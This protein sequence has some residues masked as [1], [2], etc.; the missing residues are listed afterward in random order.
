MHVGGQG[1]FKP[2]LMSAIERTGAVL[3]TWARKNLLLR[4][5]GGVSGETPQ[6]IRWRETAC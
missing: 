1:P 3:E 4:Y 6:S 5:A 2:V